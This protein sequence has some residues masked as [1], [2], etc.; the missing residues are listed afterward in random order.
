[1]NSSVVSF[2]WSLADIVITGITSGG[3]I[4]GAPTVDCGAVATDAAEILVSIAMIGGVHA[5]TFGCG[6]SIGGVNAQPCSI[7]DLIYSL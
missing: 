6:I 2:D 5:G 7:V 3:P 1:M 4:G